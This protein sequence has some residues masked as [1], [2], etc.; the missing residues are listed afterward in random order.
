[1]EDSGKTHIP[2]VSPNVS[3]SW[4]DGW[5]FVENAASRAAS[6]ASVI[7]LRVLRRFCA[8]NA[9]SGLEGAAS[10]SVLVAEE[11]DWLVKEAADVGRS[12][13]TLPVERAGGIRGGIREY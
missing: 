13:K 11:P 5:E 1:M 10:E 3:R 12:V 2:I 9:A 4:T 8:S 6:W 7:F